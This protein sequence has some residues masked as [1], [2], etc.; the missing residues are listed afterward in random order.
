VGQRITGSNISIEELNQRLFTVSELYDRFAN[1]FNLAH[2]KL[3]IL[4]CAG[5]YER[6]IVENVWVDILKKGCYFDWI[7]DGSFSW[8]YFVLELRPF[9]RNEESAEQSK[10]RIAAVLK[11]LSTQYSSM[12]K[13]YPIGKLNVGSTIG[14]MY[15]ESK[16]DI[17]NHKSL[18]P[19]NGVPQPRK[20]KNCLLKN[21]IETNCAE[22]AA[23]CL[24]TTAQKLKFWQIFS[25]L[26]L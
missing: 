21:I 1:P 17:Y 7:Y 3:A 8:H 25:D 16:F 18:M 20:R 4:A 11:S 9:E 12:L 6:E 15:G 19:T 14:G 26:C 24:P 13:F 2:I 23:G 10:R 22:D 5:H